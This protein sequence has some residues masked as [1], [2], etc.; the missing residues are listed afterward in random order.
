LKLAILAWSSFGTL[1]E[2]QL[3]L[4][5]FLFLGCLDD[6]ALELC[7]VRWVLIPI[8]PDR[9]VSQPRMAR[10]PFLE[11][12]RGSAA[13]CSVAVLDSG[14]CNGDA[15]CNGVGELSR[16]IRP[17][18]EVSDSHLLQ[19]S[20]SNRRPSSYLGSRS[21]P[22]PVVDEGK[23]PLTVSR[24]GGSLELE[25][26][27]SR[28]RLPYLDDRRPVVREDDDL[29][30]EPICYT[31]RLDDPVVDLDNR[32]PENPR[33]RPEEPLP[34]ASADRA[35]GIGMA[36]VVVSSSMMLKRFAAVS[37]AIYGPEA[38]SPRVAVV[39]SSLVALF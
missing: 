11:G 23:A 29:S 34:I 38:I 6:L 4:D 21:V 28:S 37:I 1:C 9:D 20:F 19:D 8:R 27:T 18:I 33:V 7:F 5:A 16:R 32:A 26:S 30:G 25:N 15:P 17:R 22:V 10:E 35:S 39:P 12:E 24:S 3:A 14:R 2:R 36:G 31:G 13:A